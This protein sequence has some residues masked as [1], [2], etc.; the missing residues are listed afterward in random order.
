MATI[1]ASRRLIRDGAALKNEPNRRISP[2]P[3]VPVEAIVPRTG[4]RK[5]KM[6]SRLAGVETAAKIARHLSSDGGLAVYSLSPMGL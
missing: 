2:I 3:V 4:A 5:R 6:F 1:S